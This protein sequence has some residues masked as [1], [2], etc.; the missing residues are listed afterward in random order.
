MQPCTLP[1][2]YCRQAVVNSERGKSGHVGVVEMQPRERASEDAACVRALHA[3][4]SLSAVPLP[5]GWNLPSLPPPVPPLPPPPPLLDDPQA[6]RG[7][8]RAAES[9]S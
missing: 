5:M 6:A 7:T 8:R 2:S 9:R 4:V 3:S 1:S